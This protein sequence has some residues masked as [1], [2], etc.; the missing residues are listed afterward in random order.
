MEGAGNI[1]SPA[2]E[3]AAIMFSDIAGYTAIMGRDEREAMRA[4]DAHRG[5]LRTLLPK[6]NGRLIGEIGDGTLSSFHSAIDAVNCAREVQARVEDNPELRLRIGIH[7][8]DV[9]F[10]N[11]TVIGDGVNVA[12]RIHALAPPGGICISEHVYDEIRNK[13]GVRGKDLGK[14][15][16]KNVSRPIRVY[17]LQAVGEDLS[18]GSR[19][20][21]R[22]AMGA[23]VS[24][25]L[26][27]IVAAYVHR[28]QIVT[29]MPLRAPATNGGLATVAVLPLSNLSADKSD[30]Y[31]SD[32]MTDEIIGQL[33]KITGIQVA[34]RTS[35][36]VFK[37]KSEDAAKIASLLHVR[38]LLEGSVQRNADKLRIEVQ[39]IDATNGFTLWSERYDEKMADV[40]QI[41]SDVAQSVAQS[42]RVKLIPAVRARLEKRPTDN[43]E[44]YNL[45][46][47]GRYYVRQFTGQSAGKAIQC[48][49]QAIEK[50]PKFA[51]AYQGLGDA[52]SNASSW[53]IAPRDAV[54]KA[55]SYYE[56]ALQLD[57]TL[58]EAHSGLALWVLFPYDWDWPGTEREFKRAIALDPN[59]AAAHAGYG[60]Y[61][62]YLG[63]LEEALPE[64][65][66]AREIDPLSPETVVNIGEAFMYRREYARADEYFRQAIAMA[67]DFYDS[68]LQ[69][70]W[71]LTCQGKNA[72]AVPVIEK[73]A[74]L[75]EPDF[76]Q[77]QMSLGGIYALT[78]RRAEA[79][80][81]LEHLKDLSIHQYVDPVAFWSI[82]FA[83][84]E[85]DL[86]FKWFEKGYADK[87]GYMI[88]LKLCTY[89]NWRSD[90]RFQ[91]IYKKVG[92]PP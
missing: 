50:D 25:L 28:A 65:E 17:A 27:A 21:K 62:G 91:A 37:G 41:Q 52:Y 47:Q 58:T 5:T 73:A 40:F 59:S 88:G 68:Y 20:G 63:R 18:T 84:G 36:F 79:L 35:S 10:T 86:S 60:W 42:L 45:S 82:Y 44:A 31:F 32:G 8:G 89:D 54:P 70:G 55:R 6:F 85:K 33:S 48:Y 69:Q 75:A 23:I 4:L 30:E 92:L 77:T 9:V 76:T 12:S 90:P 1:S 51:Q 39:L 81:I 22:V 80:T 87:S 67:P 19:F 71:N 13:P 14:K 15:Q 16:L 53:T 46:L 43:L 72:E 56:K 2:R 66:R 29:V 57:E 74:A 38:N 83:L 7:L 61:F 24:A 34:A 78:G 26:V 64:L 3:L 49:S 11:N